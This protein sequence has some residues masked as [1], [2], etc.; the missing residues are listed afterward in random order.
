MS[1]PI[2]QVRNLRASIA[3]Q[4]HPSWRAVIAAQE[5]ADLPPLPPGVHAV[6][7]HF[8]PNLH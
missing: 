8:P 6:R 7:V 1:A 5:G 3:G 2:L 4:Q